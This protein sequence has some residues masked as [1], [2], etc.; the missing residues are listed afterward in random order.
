MH[1][2][3]C[4]N[5]YE[6]LWG[7]RSQ[8][9]LMAQSHAGPNTMNDLEVFRCKETGQYGLWIEAI[10]SFTEGK[11]GEHRYLLYLLEQFTEWMLQNNRCVRSPAWFYNVFLMGSSINSKFDTLEELYANFRMLVNGYVSL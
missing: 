4:E 9:C 2:E 1:N 6:F 3:S 10:Y 7:V 8:D 11:V 5:D